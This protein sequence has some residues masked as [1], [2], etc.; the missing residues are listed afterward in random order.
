MAAIIKINDIAYR[1][2]LTLADI[3]LRTHLRIMEAEAHAPKRLLE[4]LMEED[5]IK[6]AQSAGM[7]TDKVYVGKIVPYFATVIQAAS[8]IPADVLLGRKNWEGAP[9]AMIE[10]WYWKVQQCYLNY[11]DVKDQQV[12]EWDINGSIWSLPE[13]HMTKSTFGQFAEAAQYEES[14]NELNAGNWAAMPYVM[15]VLLR[16]KGEVFDPFKFDDMVEERKEF[17]LDLG[18]DVVMQTAFFLLKLNEKC[19]PDLAIYTAAKELARLKR[20]MN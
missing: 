7:I 9:V 12:S 18:M 11:Q 15:A 14:V 16:P 10:T 19:A 5:P 4:I 6:R 20:I 13:R 17:M 1:L 3:S 2:P 8:G